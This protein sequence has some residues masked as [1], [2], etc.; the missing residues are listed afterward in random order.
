VR[1][2]V[3]VVAA[4]HQP[5]ARRAQE[6]SFRADLFYRL[7]VF[8]IET[9][10]LAEHADDLAALIEHFLKAV[11][12]DDDAPKQLSEA[13]FAQLTAHKWPGNVRELQHV[14]ER[15]S[16]LAEDRALITEAEIEFDL[17]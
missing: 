1:V 10:A 15:A 2:D 17:P 5:L 6:G 11:A 3:R 14:L 13:A 7:S 4:T 9:P 12:G 8:R 16:I